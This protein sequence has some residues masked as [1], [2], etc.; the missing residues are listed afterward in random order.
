[1]EYVI[2]NNKKTMTI[3]EFCSEYG[4]GINKA[5][6]LVH[7]KDFPKIKCGRKIIILRSK[8]DEFFE[9]HIGQEF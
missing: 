8:V 6:E 5:Y 4:I 3:K 1:M 7:S 2:N 9:S